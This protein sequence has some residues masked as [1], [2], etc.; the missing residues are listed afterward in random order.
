MENQ[1]L[2]FPSRQCSSTPAVFGQGFLSKEQCDNT[3]APSILSWPG[4]S[5]FLLVPATEISIEGTALLWF[6]WHHEECDGRAEKAF[7]KWLARMFPTTLQSLADVYSCKWEYFEGNVAA[8]IMLFYFSDIK[9]FREHI[10]ATTH[11]E[12]YIFR[13][14]L[15]I[16]DQTISYGRTISY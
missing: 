10:Q 7:T 12:A 16:I 1:K 4:C 5:W 14:D 8:M 6:Y 2:A 15:P 11:Y 3:G 13:S 9:W